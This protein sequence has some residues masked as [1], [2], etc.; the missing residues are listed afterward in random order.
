M[1]L[2]ESTLSLFTENNMT[3]LSPDA[4]FLGN[5]GIQ[6]ISF[7][8][9]HHFQSNQMVLINNSEVPLGI[10]EQPSQIQTFHEYRFNLEL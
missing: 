9:W 3:Q 4:V 8:I 10:L 6:I 7:N 5:E 1:A 2:K